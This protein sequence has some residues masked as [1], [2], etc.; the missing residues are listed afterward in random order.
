MQPFPGR[1]DSGVCHAIVSPQ[2]QT[3]LQV[4]RAFLDQSIA[5]IEKWLPPMPAGLIF[6]IDECGL[7]DWEER[8]A[9][10]VRIPSRVRDATV[11]YPVDRGIRHQ[12]LVC[13]VTAAGDAYS[14][15][16]VLRGRSVTQIVD[17]GVRDETDFKIEITSS[18]H[19]TQDVFNKYIDEV[20]IPVVLSN[21]DVPGWK[22][23][24]AILFCENC[25]AHR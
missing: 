18:R 4:P 1:N 16:L 2:E 8:K 10:P 25:S 9:K 22:D 24:R 6:I 19:V 11:H 3:R 14:P 21:R 5:L 15:L 23:K 20:L 7:R 17:P 13:F 12:T